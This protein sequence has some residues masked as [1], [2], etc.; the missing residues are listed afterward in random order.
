MGD[1]MSTN[2]E[3][4][5]LEV[6][7]DVKKEDIENLLKQYQMILDNNFKPI[8]MKGPPES[9]VYRLTTTDKQAYEKFI[10]AVKTMNEYVVW[11]DGPTAPYNPNR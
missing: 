8:L 2:L 7:A 6:P 11:G 10:D 5:M 1:Y 3:S 4:C 9:M